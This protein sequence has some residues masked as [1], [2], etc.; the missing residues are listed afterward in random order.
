MNETTYVIA[1]VII[2]NIHLTINITEYWLPCARHWQYKSEQ[3]RCQKN[4]YSLEL[5]VYLRWRWV[6]VNGTPC[7]SV[8]RK[9]REG[10]EKIQ[11]ERIDLYSCKLLG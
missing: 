10:G 5:T 11:R 2:G 8:W 1:E 3:N 6:K 7:G 4:P 9:L